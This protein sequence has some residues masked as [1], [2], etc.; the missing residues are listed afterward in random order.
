MARSRRNFIKNC[1]LLG[2][3]AG[4]SAPNTQSSSASDST[5]VG[6]TERTHRVLVGI[7]P[8]D[9]EVCEQGGL[10]AEV[11]FVEDLGDSGEIEKGAREPVDLVD[12]H[13]IDEAG[14][15]IVEQLLECR[16][17][18]VRARVAAVVVSFR[19]RDPAFMALAAN[20]RLGG[21]ALG[22]ER[23]VFLVQALLGRLPGVDGAEIGRAHV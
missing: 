16:A 7:R 17:V 19:Q 12:H 11:E 4:A 23:I 3:A 6:G 14:A 15:N 13:A 2:A 9:L 22:I 10:A 1:C 8:G 18:H 20:E 21:I 5:S